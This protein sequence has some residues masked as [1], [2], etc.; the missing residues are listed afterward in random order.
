[1]Y[2]KTIL[3]CICILVNL[4]NLFTVDAYD[5][6]PDE[7]SDYYLRLIENGTLKPLNLLETLD[8][9]KYY[10]IL[11]FLPVNTDVNNYY[12]NISIRIILNEKSEKIFTNIEEYYNDIEYY[13]HFEIQFIEYSIWYYEIFFNRYIGVVG[14]PTGKCF[15][16][17]F[18]EDYE[19]IR[20]IY[21]R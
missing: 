10:L 8:T 6:L 18:N 21:W 13:G 2:R 9:E 7:I 12:Y 1:M 4:I 11:S 16:L 19:F 15:S 3:F 5:G 20:R 17:L 14:D